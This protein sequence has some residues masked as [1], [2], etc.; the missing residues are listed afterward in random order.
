MINKFA[1][2]P[3]TDERRDQRKALEVFYN[4]QAQ[5]KGTQ[6]IQLEESHTKK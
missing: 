4:I 2:Q 6:M 5:K 3:E 1:T